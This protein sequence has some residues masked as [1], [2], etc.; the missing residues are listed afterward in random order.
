MKVYHSSTVMV[1]SPDISYS[2]AYLDFGP[3]F[4][5]TTIKEQAEKYAERFLRRGKEAWLNVYELKD[6][7]SAW[8]VLSFDSYDEKWLDY[9]AM[10][11]RGVV[12]ND[13]DLIIGGIANDRVFR[14]ID[15][16]FSGDITKSEALSRLVYEKPNVQFCIRSQQMLD[17][18]LTFI[19]SSKL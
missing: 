17:S 7:L 9:V 2:R 12:E 5:V 3:G 19:G 8:R 4:Y 18:C 15:L 11:R 10:C 1:K 14:T 13:Y 6:D 16:Y